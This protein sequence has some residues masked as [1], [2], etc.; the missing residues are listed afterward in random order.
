MQ[1]DF[2]ISEERNNSSGIV[3]VL[4]ILGSILVAYALTNGFESA[5]RKAEREAR[6][7]EQKRRADLMHEQGLAAIREEEAAMRHQRFMELLPFIAIIT[8]CMAA[9]STSTVVLFYLVARHR[10][11]LAQ[12]EQAR[13]DAPQ[14]R[15]LTVTY[16]AMLHPPVPGQKRADYWRDVEA[17]AQDGRRAA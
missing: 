12:I 13:R 8:A 5:E 10:E 2:R 17:R 14:H 3:F 9:T 7:Y 11:R 15:T 6:I 1:L 4:F 16:L